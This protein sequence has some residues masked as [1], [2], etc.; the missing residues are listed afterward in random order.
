MW[1]TSHLQLLWLASWPVILWYHLAV[2]LKF[3]ASSCK[4]ILT[5]VGEYSDI[6][7]LPVLTSVPS[8]KL[9]ERYK[10]LS[11]QKT[12]WMMTCVS[13]VTLSCLYCIQLCFG[14][15]TWISVVHH[16]YSLK[17]PYALCS[18]SV[19]GQWSEIKLM[20]KRDIIEHP[21]ESQ[22]SA[23]DLIMTTTTTTAIIIIMPLLCHTLI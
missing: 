22:H 9:Q 14:F 11:H 21:E 20:R 16:S 13:N 7:V 19:E 3:F 4:W 18:I 2:S 17:H 23:Q 15:S 12:T 10:K 1:N 8:K 5:A 6:F